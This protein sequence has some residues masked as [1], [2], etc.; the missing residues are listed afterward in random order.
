MESPFTN[1]PIPEMETYPEG[2]EIN[3]DVM[4]K[5]PFLSAEE[6]DSGLREEM[7]EEE[8]VDEEEMEFDFHES[9]EKGVDKNNKFVEGVDWAEDQNELEND[10]DEDAA[11][12]NEETENVDPS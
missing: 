6:M 10:E 7:E 8:M 11:A 12:N 3:K 9:E 5:S 1:F 4:L 2:N